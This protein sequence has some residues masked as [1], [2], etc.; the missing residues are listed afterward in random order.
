MSTT[1]L[2]STQQDWIESK[3]KAGDEITRD[4]HSV[5]NENDAPPM[6]SQDQM[7]RAAQAD[8]VGKIEAL[9]FMIER[10]G[11]E[12]VFGYQAKLVVPSGPA[13]LELA[14]KL[15]DGQPLHQKIVDEIN[16]QREK[17][18]G[19]I[20]KSEAYIGEDAKAQ[21]DRSDPHPSIKHP[22]W[23]WELCQD[24]RFMDD[25]LNTKAQGS[26]T[27]P[28]N[29]RRLRNHVYRWKG[30][31]PAGMDGADLSTW[32]TL[33]ARGLRTGLP[34]DQALQSESGNN[35]WWPESESTLLSREIAVEGVTP[36]IIQASYY[37]YG[38]NPWGLGRLN[39]NFGSHQSFKLRAGVSGPV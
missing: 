39:G 28:D 3:I 11:S 23:Y 36:W 34:I 38:E 16:H 22:T 30:A 7:I 17:Q 25:E 19:R 27:T 4:V 33:F 12:G 10:D 6:P 18:A 5:L 21:L 20:W 2:T 37:H 9:D 31:L 13:R 8:L 14:Q 26:I 24:G 1:R 35:S 32:A 29:E 15:I